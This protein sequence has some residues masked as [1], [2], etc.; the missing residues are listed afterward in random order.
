MDSYAH[1]E[2]HSAT[3][4]GSDG[5]LKNRKLKGRRTKTCSLHCVLHRGLR[6][7][8]EGYVTEI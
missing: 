5:V 4:F 8:S 1:M 3:D 2:G 7:P 6:C